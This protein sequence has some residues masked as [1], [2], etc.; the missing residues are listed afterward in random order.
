[1]MAT[2]LGMISIQK[3]EHKQKQETNH[4]LN[5]IRSNMTLLHS[6]QL[7]DQQPKTTIWKRRE[8]FL[9]D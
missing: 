5:P 6:K 4:T 2:G 1:M 7:Q 9:T 8:Y 3:E